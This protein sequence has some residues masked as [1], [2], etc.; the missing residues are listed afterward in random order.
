MKL[1]IGIDA[2]GTKTRSLGVSEDGVVRVDLEVAGA[3]LP[4]RGEEEV[5]RVLREL[6]RELEHRFEAGD[7]VGGIALGLPGYGETPTWS[8]ALEDLA[9]SVFADLP[10]RVYNDVRFALEGAFAGEPGVIVL[11]G[12]GSMAWGKRADGN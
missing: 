12:T 10:Y 7:R 6:R 1:F 2:G 8:S 4:T 5:A 11:S 3:D 9:A